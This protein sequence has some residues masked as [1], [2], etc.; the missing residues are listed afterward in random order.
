M[1][2]T[3][4]KVNEPKTEED[5]VSESG[6]SGGSDSESG[7]KTEKT[8]ADK[9]HD[10]FT[11]RIK[12][13]KE[14]IANLKK[15]VT[16]LEKLQRDVKKEFVAKVPKKK[17]S[18]NTNSAFKLPVKISNEMCKF[19]KLEKGTQIPRTEV[20]K[21]LCAWVKERPVKNEEDKRIIDINCKAAAPLKK[22]MKK[23]SDEDMEKFTCFTMQKYIQHHYI[24]G[25]KKG[26]VS[27]KT[28]KA[29]SSK[30]K[31]TKA[32]KDSVEPEAVST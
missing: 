30:A 3:D 29:K 12:S 23:I 19:L 9:I 14:Q 2:E 4:T 1:A 15:E 13:L 28:N 7:E 20:T 31:T 6:E 16:A 18:G 32:K 11:T 22:I 25:E 17:R 5:V 27:P 24:K 10:V 21:L 8:N 26:K